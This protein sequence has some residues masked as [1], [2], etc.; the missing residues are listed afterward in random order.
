MTKFKLM[1]SQAK[2]ASMGEM[3]G[4]IA[5]QWR[6][7]LSIITTSVSAIEVKLDMQGHVSDEE[8]LKCTQNVINQANYHLKHDR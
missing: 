3:I 4:N 1:E 6:Q 7:P 2:L 8:I 5:H